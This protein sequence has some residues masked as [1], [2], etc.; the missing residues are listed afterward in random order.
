MYSSRYVALIP[1]EGS[2]QPY[3]ILLPGM[4]LDFMATCTLI[5]NNMPYNRHNLLALDG[6]SRVVLCSNTAL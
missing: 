4:A 3:N 5:L 1:L 2:I 6:E